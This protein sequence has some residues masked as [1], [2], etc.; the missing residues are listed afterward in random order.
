[1][2]AEYEDGIYF[3]TIWEIRDGKWSQLIRGSFSDPED[4]PAQDE[5]G[6]DIYVNYRMAGEDVTEVEFYAILD[7]YVDFDLLEE[8]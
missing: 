1:M 4:G 8:V 3:V 6:N 7:T 2:V 5:D